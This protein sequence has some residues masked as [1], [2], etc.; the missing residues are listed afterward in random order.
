MRKLWD[1]GGQCLQ[2]L[3]P[4]QQFELAELLQRYWVLSLHPV[5]TKIGIYSHLNSFNSSPQEPETT[6][7]LMSQNRWQHVGS[8]LAL[9]VRNKPDVVS[10][11]FKNI[12]IFDVLKLECCWIFILGT[13]LLTP[14]R[15]PLHFF[16]PCSSCCITVDVYCLSLSSI[17]TSDLS[18]MLSFPAY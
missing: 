8:R 14:S 7:N 13:T 18:L 10:T 17:A 9:L 15:L 5:L 2:A 3:A 12:Y 6:V 11:P 1:S 4:V 16:L